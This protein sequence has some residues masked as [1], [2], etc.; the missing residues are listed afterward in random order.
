MILAHGLVFSTCEDPMLIPFTD[1]PESEAYLAFSQ[2]IVPRPIAWILSDNGAGAAP[3]QRW[4][5]APYSYFNAIT[6]APPM[7]MFSIGDGMAGKIKD[8]H[9]NLRAMAHCVIHIA[10]SSQAQ[11]L[12]D[13]AAE[14]PAGVSEVHETGLALVD[15]DWPVP[16]IADAPCALGCVATQF[17]R[18]GNTDQMVVFAR[19]ER[20]WLRDDIVSHDDKGRLVVDVERYDPLAR[21]GRGGYTR[22][23]PVFRP[24]IR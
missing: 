20:L 4:N 18:V 6:S 3:E 14:L 8:T 1:L 16:R 17:T 13:T 21:V 12:Q 2:I 22:L 15:W 5:L 11:V 23:G 24:T 19:I 10:A 7:V 9:R